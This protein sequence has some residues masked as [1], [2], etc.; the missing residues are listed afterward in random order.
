MTPE[1]NIRN[2]RMTVVQGRVA[3]VTE[4]VLDHKL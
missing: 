3:T 1:K 2:F 4:I